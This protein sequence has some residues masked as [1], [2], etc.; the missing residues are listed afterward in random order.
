MKKG[1]TKMMI[2]WKV[3]GWR[4]WGT[5]EYKTI[6]S[7]EQNIPIHKH[8]LRHRLLEKVKLRRV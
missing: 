4:T 6:T 2:N 3:A 5:Y 1:L 7:T 8:K